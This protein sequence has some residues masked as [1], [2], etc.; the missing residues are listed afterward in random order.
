VAVPMSPARRYLMSLC[1]CS[2][3]RDLGAG[4]LEARL[5]A[6]LREPD[7]GASVAELLAQ[8]PGLAEL[9][10]RREQ[11]VTGLVAEIRDAVRARVHVV[12]VGEPHAA[13]MDLAAVAAA[14]DRLTVL[15]Y[16]PRAVDEQLAPAAAAC[17][18]DRLVAG[19]TLCDPDTPDE[20]A[21]RER[22]DAV[23][24]LGIDAVSI[25]HHSLVTADRLRWA[26]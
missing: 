14:A 6:R 2:A 24:D 11:A 18:P 13:G 3:C 8:E 10:R 20:A 19:L 4:E 21:F 15:A 25:Y 9:Q 22:L 17:G 26:A 5:T 16:R 1:R 23:R 7:G 12:H